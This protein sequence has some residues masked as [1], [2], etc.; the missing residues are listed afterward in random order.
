M[1]NEHGSDNKKVSINQGMALAV[2]FHSKGQIDRAKSILKTILHSV[3]QHPHALH[4]LGVITHNAG[5][6]ETAIK[7]LTQAVSIFPKES[8]FFS[9]LCEMCRKLKR[10]EEAVRYGEMAISL[11]PD[12]AVAH[13]NL[14]IAY[15]DSELMDKARA[16]QKKALSINPNSIPA[17]NNMGS[18]ARK[19]KDSDGAISYYRQVIDKAPQHLESINNLGAVLTESEEPEEAVKILIGALKLNPDYYEAHGNIALAFLAMEQLE[20]A[21]L[22]FRKALSLNPDFADGFGGLAKI[23]QDRKNL[24]KAFEMAEKSLA[25]SPES[26]KAHALIGGI[27][28]DSGYP[29]KAA[30]HFK[31]AL[32]I[33]PDLI[34]AHL[35][36]GHLAMEMGNMV[37]AEGAFRHAIQIDASSLNAKLALAQ[38]TK[39]SIDDSNFKNLI[40]EMENLS[41][42][43]ETKALPLH[44]ALGKC[45]DDTKQFDLAFQHYKEGC[46]L[47]R[48]RTDYNPIDNDKAVADIRSI[49]SKETIDRLRGSGC[50]SNTPI[51]VLG[52]PRSG[53]TLTEQIIASHPDAHGAGEL[54]DLLRLANHPN[55][56][57]ETGYPHSIKGL[58]SS[59]IQSMGEKYVS[60]LIERAPEAKFIT[61]KMPANFNCVGLIH[62]MLPN[63][64]I[65]HVKRNPIDTCLSGFSRLFNKTQNH[66]YDLSEI[67]RYYRNYYD[68]MAHWKEVLPEASYYEIQYEELV[69]DTETQ[70][71]ALIDYCGLD[72]N[73]ACLDFHK[74]E[75]SIRT[76]SVTQV[77]QPIYTTSVE[78]WRTYEDHLEPLFDAL[79]DL[80][81]R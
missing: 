65:I 38:C 6:T 29:E 1:A 13:S 41:D 36:Q 51:F 39:S 81:V 61:D 40:A 52:M 30:L 59:Q 63:A 74:T 32:E 45:Y 33:D 64:K 27:C 18:I 31:D 67:G 16:A 46:R 4:L 50:Q 35:G 34:A 44:F 62:L 37:A 56:W 22:G 73:E 5:D 55:G 3:P 20:K 80:A 47:K 49:F 8:Q 7:M 17:L 58:S 57:E 11:S 15:Y 72:W 14:G 77:R 9:N 79:G 71:K 54:P 69:A 2:K 76:A 10:H 75:R 23:Y 19:N 21:E 12:S 68:L 42:M 70:S 66:S 53:T 25:L 48:K 43:R 26:A 24:T 60:G 28:A 78:R